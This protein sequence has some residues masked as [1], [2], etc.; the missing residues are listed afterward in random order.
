MT[1]VLFIDCEGSTAIL[2][3]KDFDIDSQIFKDI[4]DLTVRIVISISSLNKELS[5]NDI[6]R[7]AKWLIIKLIALK[8]MEDK[9]MLITGLRD[10][11]RFDD[12]NKLF[13]NAYQYTGSSIFNKDNGIDFE[14]HSDI[15]KVITNKLYEYDFRYFPYDFLGTVYELFLSKSFENITKRNI[16]YEKFNTNNPIKN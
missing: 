11:K 12:I 9:K 3:M 4:D 2:I 6:D 14:I 13:N 8:F 5:S 16:D 15:I 1:A 10:I 7:I